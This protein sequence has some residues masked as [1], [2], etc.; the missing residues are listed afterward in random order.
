MRT[1][2]SIAGLSLLA[3][4]VVGP[5]GRAA[6]KKQAKPTPAEQAAVAQLRKKGALVLELAQNDH[7]LDVAFHLVGAKI[8]DKDLPPLKALS[9]R[10][11][12]LNLAGTSVTDAGL[13]QLAGLTG[14]ARLHLEKTKITDKGLAN[15]KGLR[16][17]EYL[18]VYG[19]GVTDAGLRE[20]A[21]L[22]GLKKVFIWQSKVTLAGVAEF[23][24]THPKAQIIPDLI[25]EKKRAE[26]R[27]RAEAAAKKKAAAAKKK[28]AAK[29]TKKKPGKK[30]PVKKK[31]A[32]KKPAVKKSPA[33]KKPAAKKKK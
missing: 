7:R 27:K 2:L 13:S 9:G 28:A 11:Y 6:E 33:K 29:K 14:L 19:T 4:L 17:L 25:V 32:K 31:P 20:L 3:V 21:G 23:H 30:K 1:F 26:A 22:K 18:N 8:G 15:L 12:S 24:K 5:A 10:L 16:H